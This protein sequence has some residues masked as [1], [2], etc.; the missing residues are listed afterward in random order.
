A[1]RGYSYT[2]K[3]AQA[4][5]TRDI[6]KAEAAPRAGKN[7]ITTDYKI[8]TRLPQIDVVIDATCST[9]TGALV[10]LDCFDRKKHIVMMNVECDV[11]IGPILGRMAE[12]VGV[13]YTL[14]CSLHHGQLPP[15]ASLDSER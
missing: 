13:V 5:S 1:A 4:L 10:S 8:A 11:T 9:E 6:E 7:V 12:N 3:N 14:V 2:K 15:K